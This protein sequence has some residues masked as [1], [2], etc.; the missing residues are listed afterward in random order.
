ME[1]LVFTTWIALTLVTLITRL[2]PLLV[3]KWVKRQYWAGHL[4]GQLPGMILFLLLIHTLED[5]IWSV[6]P[7]TLAAVFGLAATVTCHYV[8]RNTILSITIGVL[9]YMAATWIVGLPF[10]AAPPI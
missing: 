6:G 3:G 10:Y 1:Q 7:E 5:K 2:A 9:V 8:K 4:A